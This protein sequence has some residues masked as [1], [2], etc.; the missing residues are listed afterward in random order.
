M[1]TTLIKGIHGNIILHPM[2]NIIYAIWRWTME[3]IKGIHS[4]T[5]LYPTQNITYPIPHWTRGI[6]SNIVS[7]VFNVKISANLGHF[8]KI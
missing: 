7:Y 6:H 8:W 4:S 2:P 5:V 3:S 1:Y